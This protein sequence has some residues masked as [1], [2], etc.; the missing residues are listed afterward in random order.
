MTLKGNT[1]VQEERRR[2]A[3][4]PNDVIRVVPGLIGPGGFG[5]GGRSGGDR[6]GDKGG[7]SSPGVR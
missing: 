4:T 2:P 6:G 1:C 5:G 3:V 7:G